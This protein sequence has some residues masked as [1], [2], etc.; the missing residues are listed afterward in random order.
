MQK[1]HSLPIIVLAVLALVLGHSSA[2]DVQDDSFSGQV[3]LEGMIHLG[4]NTTPEWEEAAA[5]PDGLGEYV[6][7]FKDSIGDSERALAFT[8]RDA[9]SEWVV[10]INGKY[11]CTLKHRGEPSEFVVPVPKGIIR[12]GVNTFTLST[13]KSGDDLTFGRVKISDEPYS[14][15]FDL[16][17]ISVKCVDSNGSPLACR[18]SIVGS[19]DSLAKTH[20]ADK[21]PFPTRDGVV[22][23]NLDGIAEV[24]VEAGDYTIT[25]SHGPEFSIDQKN[26][27]DSG[28]MSYDLNFNL[29][30]EVDTTGWLSADTHL[31]TYTHSGHGDASTDERIITLAGDHTEIAISTDHNKQIDYR[32][33]MKKH[34]VKD[35]YTHIT[36]NEVSTDLGHFNSFPLPADGA[37]PDASITNWALLNKE[38]RDKGAEV[39]ILNH[40]RWPSFVKGPFGVQ[41]LNQETGLFTS[42][43]DLAVDAIELINSDDEG[44]PFDVSI[45]DWFALL[46]AGNHVMAA[47]SS[48]SHAVY[49]PTGLGRTWVKSKTDVPSKATQRRIAANI[50]DGHSSAALGL[51]GVVEIN[52]KGSGEQLKQPMSGLNLS[53]R[54]AHA[55]WADVYHIDVYVNGEVVHQI[56]VPPHK[57]IAFDKTFNHTLADVEQDSWVVCVAY[58]KRP[59]AWWATDFPELYFAS[60]P[61]FIKK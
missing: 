47:G 57:D 3:I 54:I 24:L 48:D 30:H 11:V 39:V 60:N 36:G 50:R 2:T 31:H 17:A 38:I 58:G 19:D 40:P 34:G 52:G 26:I 7:K 46:N 6:F 51:F 20:F 44:S 53:F 43:I 12:K 33:T 61:I 37:I 14:E 18:I 15:V 28:E 27:T 23:T 13:E 10:K 59:G 55:S 22:Y 42:G 56:E 9:H 1:T 49:V 16:R 45:K 25:A 32:P 21:S 41:E 8:T 29:I 5:E 4:D 35:E